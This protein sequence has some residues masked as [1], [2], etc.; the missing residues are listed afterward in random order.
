M[1]VAMKQKL[2]VQITAFAIP[3]LLTALLRP[4]SPLLTLAGVWLAWLSALTVSDRVARLGAGAR[5]VLNAAALL[6]ACGIVVNQ[7][8]FTVHSGGTDCAP[9]LL[10]DDAF[11][12]WVRMSGRGWYIENASHAGY[13]LMVRRLCFGSP[14]LAVALS[15]NMLGCLLTLVCTGALARLLYGDG[16]GAANRVTVWLSM[17]VVAAN[18]Y[19]LSCGT[20][21]LRDSWICLATACIIY[22]L[23][24]MCLRGNYT[25]NDMVGFGLLL[26]ALGILRSQMLMLMLPGTLVL[27]LLIGRRYRR[28]LLL[29]VLTVA[30]AF[31]TDQL[32]AWLHA[33]QGSFVS[34][35]QLT[36]PDWTVEPA[37]RQMPLSSIA[38]HLPS[39]P[40]VVRLLWLPVFALVQFLIPFPWNFGR[41]IVFGPTSAYAHIAYPGYL[42]GIVLGYYVFW[43]MRR[44]GLSPPNLLLFW[45]ALCY[46]AVAVAFSGTVSR[47]ALPFLPLSA[48]VIA[49]TLVECGRR[50]SLWIW[51]GACS[52][53]MCAGLLVCHHLQ[54]Q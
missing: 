46:C 30:V 4:D 43:L 1:K 25:V 7:W 40:L 5:T 49:R 18:C 22:Q 47:Y 10:N 19:W 29:S 13:P 34:T 44:R 45:G 42:A 35:A 27:P 8:Y 52:T 3:A 32:A 24:R 2:M 37:R 15:L 53:L 17:A 20:L 54:T 11:D 33:G 31:A 6:M 14:S 16:T 39:M 23:A 12:Y 9:V 50:R 21:L 38:G 36:G 28:A 41:D 26:F 48:P 51:T